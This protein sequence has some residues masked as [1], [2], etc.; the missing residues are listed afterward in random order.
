MLILSKAYTDLRG[1]DPP[2]GGPLLNRGCSGVGISNVWPQRGLSSRRQ[3][4]IQFL[5]GQKVS[6]QP[7]LSGQPPVLS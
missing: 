6:P 5:C 3:D 2:A 4:L 7:S 1:R